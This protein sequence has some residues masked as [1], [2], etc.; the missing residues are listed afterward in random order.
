MSS[1]IAWGPGLLT[2]VGFG[3][4]MGVNP[5]L[6][7]ATADMLARN[8]QA[9]ARLRWM[10]AG[11][12]V[13]ATLLLALFHS[14][15]PTSIVQASRGKLDAVLV[16]QTIDIIAAALF[17]IAAGVVLWWKRRTPQLPRKA[18]KSPKPSARPYSYFFLG[19]GACV[20]FTTLPIM[21]LT[22][23]LIA[24]LTPDLLLRVIAYVVFLAALVAPFFALAW[25]WAR[26]PGLSDRI[27][28]FYAA[29][30]TWDYRFYLAALLCAAGLLFVW[31][32]FF[33]PA[34]R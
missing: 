16:N 23:R 20:G 34:I 32:A 17:L 19:L 21:Y 22:G 27:T 18:A 28:R 25:V 24:G 7:G 2:L 14:V 33:D 31:L 29:A 11:L 13:G 9:T 8:V 12:V 30:Q 15:N 3:L 26:I 5:A 10:A 6:Y 4:A 1:V